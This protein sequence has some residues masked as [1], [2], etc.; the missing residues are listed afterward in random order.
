MK[1]LSTFSL[2][3]LT[4]LWV[5]LLSTLWIGL[6]STLWEERLSS[7]IGLAGLPR[8][9]ET[10]DP[11]QWGEGVVPWNTEDP[12]AEAEGVMSCA[13]FPDR[14]AAQASTHSPLW[15]ELL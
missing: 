11:Q 4:T 9:R 1:L 13:L 15:E 7:A 6:L 2:E 10:K 5:G 12:A 14:Q 8:T 3:L